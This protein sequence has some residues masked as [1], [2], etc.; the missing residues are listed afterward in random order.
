MLHPKR[1]IYLTGFLSFK[2][3]FLLYLEK[4]MLLNL[5]YLTYTIRD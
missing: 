4:P 1:E 3:I 2:I 5:N